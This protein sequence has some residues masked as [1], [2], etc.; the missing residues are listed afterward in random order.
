M[1]RYKET[2]N[3]LSLEILAAIHTL[4]GNRCGISHMYRNAHKYPHVSMW[5][6]RKDLI[7]RMIFSTCFFL[8]ST[9]IQIKS[10]KLLLS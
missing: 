9:N 6:C 5:I 1:W 7:I 2:N 8:C 4:F 3:F 10:E